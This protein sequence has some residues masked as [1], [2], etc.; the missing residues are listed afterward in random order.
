MFKRLAA[1]IVTFVVLA[2]V[3]CVAYFVWFDRTIPMDPSIVRAGGQD[4]AG[5]ERGR[6]LTR[7]LTATPAIM[8]PARRLS[9]GGG[10]SRPR[11]AS[12]SRRILRPTA[13]PE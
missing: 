12:F 9:P 1:L 10:P 6:Y 11:L 13:R 2:L 8:A 4:F 3:V 5:I 7:R